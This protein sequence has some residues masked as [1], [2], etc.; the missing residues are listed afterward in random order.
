MVADVVR[1]GETD[2]PILVRDI[3]NVRAQLRTETL[4]GRTPI[5]ALVAQLDEHELFTATRIDLDG[6]L[7][8]LF[9]AFR[10]AV[11]LYKSYP[12]VLLFDCT[13]KT[14]RFSMPLLNVIG[15]T[16]IGT[17]FYLAYVFLRAEL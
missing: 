16:G 1:H 14:N 17:S 4:A 5:Q 6:H 15:I 9:F 13:Y 7:T 12:E 2:S 8:H 3:Y 11:D 10:E